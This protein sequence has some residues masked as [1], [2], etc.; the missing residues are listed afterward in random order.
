MLEVIIVNYS[1]ALVSKCST[2]SLLRLRGGESPPL[3]LLP[4]VYYGVLL[5]LC[6]FTPDFSYLGKKKR[7]V[8][9][10][11]STACSLRSVRFLVLFLPPRSPVHTGMCYVQLAGFYFG[12]IKTTENTQLVSAH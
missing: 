11:P 2:F 1:C 9:F 7:L 5:L 3:S 12:Y 6:Q 10:N 8:R 4:L